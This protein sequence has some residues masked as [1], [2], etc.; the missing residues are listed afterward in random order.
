MRVFGKALIFEDEYT[1]FCWN[2]FRVKNQYSTAFLSVL[3]LLVAAA[4]V[5]QHVY[6][7]VHYGVV[8][9]CKFSNETYHNFDSIMTG[10]DIVIFDFGLLH[11]LLGTPNCVANHMDGGYCRLLWCLY[12]A[13]ASALTAVVVF[14]RVPRP[15]LLIPMLL[16]QSMYFMG[17]IVLVTATSPKIL[18]ALFGAYD[19]KVYLHLLIFFSCF[20]FNSYLT[21]SIWHFYW[22]WKA[23]IKLQQRKQGAKEQR[24]SSA[25]HVGTY[26]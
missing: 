13:P 16:I 11:I 26:V 19:S 22:F 1:L 12:H 25:R 7:M 18:S 21:F 8:L 10:S 2:R 6:S 3:Q 9:K 17:L 4:S 5:T 15:R 23:Q 20:A 14:S 24:T